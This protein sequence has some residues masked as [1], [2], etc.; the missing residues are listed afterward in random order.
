M[1]KDINKKEF[2]EATLL[3]LEI[4]R[5]CFREWLPVFIH[6]PLLEKVFIYDFFAGSGLDIQGNYGSPLILIEEAKGNDQKYCKNVPKGKVTFGL[7]EKY[8]GKRDELEQNVGEFIKDCLHNCNRTECVY[9]FGYG[10]FDFKEAIGRDNVKK[11]LDNR[12][13]GKFVLLDQYGFSQVDQD[14]F[15]KLVRAPFTDFIFFI[16]SS[17]IRRFKEH[18]YINKYIE[19]NKI[20]FDESQPKE[21]HKYVAEYFRTLIPNDIE[22]YLHHFTIKK[23]A[24]Y[25]GLIFGSGHTLGMEKFIKVCWSK[26]KMAGES[27]FRMNNDFESDSLFYTETETIKLRGYKAELTNGILTGKISNNIMGMKHALSCGVPTKVYLE[28]IEGLLSQVII[29]GKFNK[30]ILNIHRLKGD[31]I[32]QI[33]LK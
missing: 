19:A 26:D 5:E 29:E 11:I 30:K 31:D 25:Y 28:V 23:G 4:F 21:C 12:K 24:N 16:S 22:Y 17:F 13:Y 8:E 2:D 3:K 27:N 20:N 33:K 7:N 1:A 18:P 32:Y 9:Q 10:N 15:V 6:S 14:V